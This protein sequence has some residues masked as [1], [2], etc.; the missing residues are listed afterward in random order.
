[1]AYNIFKEGM[2]CAETS[3]CGIYTAQALQA[4]LSARLGDIHFTAV[5]AAVLRGK[6]LLGGCALRHIHRADKMAGKDMS[7]ILK[8]I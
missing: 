2:G 4:E 3:V 1:M 8:S 7:L 5:A 6:A